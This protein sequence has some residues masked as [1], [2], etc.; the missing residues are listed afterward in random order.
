MADSP[1]RTPIPVEHP[2]DDDTGVPQPMLVVRSAGELEGRVLAIRPGHQIIGRLPDSELQLDD[3]FVSRRHAIVVRDGTSVTIQDTGSVN[4]TSVNGQPLVGDPRALRSGD[5]VQVGRIRLLYLSGLETPRRS[6]SLLAPSGAAPPVEVLSRAADDDTPALGPAAPAPARQKADALPLAPTQLAV[7]AVAAAVTA[8]LLSG[9]HV[10]R[11]GQSW[12][13]SMGAAAVTSVVATVLQT[14][15]RGHWLRLAGGAG[16]AFALAVTGISLPELG[17]QRALTNQDRPATFVPPQLAPTTSST[18]PTTSAPPTTEPPPGPHIAIDPGGPVSCPDAAVGQVVTCPAVTIRS[19]GSTALVVG[20]FDL[21]EQVPGEFQVAA[22]SS[23]IGR[24]LSLD[25]TC[26]V[27]LTF[28]PAQ[29]GLRSARLVVH[30]NLPS[31]DTGTPVELTGQG[32][33]A[34]TTT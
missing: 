27:E 2:V 1:P 23:C 14:R 8:L 30:Q 11:L 10:D 4:G 6:Q 29:T 28:R 25:E 26:T 22:G 18:P 31:P 16:L 32:V 19:T 34:T 12:L 17:L 3:G 7:S 9:L 33:D 20:S 13:G 15:G 5:V 21:V 24:P